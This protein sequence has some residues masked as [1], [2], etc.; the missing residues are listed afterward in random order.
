[1]R[2][3]HT[4]SVEHLVNVFIPYLRATYDSFLSRM[5]DL[6][7]IAARYG[8]TNTYPLRLAT[9]DFQ[10]LMDFGLLY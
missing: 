5:V 9:H 1:M 3:S 2:H 7:R 6:V 8:Y 10:S 4:G